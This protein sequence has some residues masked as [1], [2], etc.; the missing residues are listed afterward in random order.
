VNRESITWPTL[1]FSCPFRASIVIPPA[2]R[3]MPRKESGGEGRAL[4][5]VAR[6]SGIQHGSRLGREPSRF[7]SAAVV[8][9]MAGPEGGWINSQV[10]RVNGGFA[11]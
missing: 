5:P 1:P 7:Y 10:L 11:Y 3:P 6:A 9:F 2:S 4:H 8:S